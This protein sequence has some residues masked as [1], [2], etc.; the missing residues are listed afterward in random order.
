MD[1]PKRSVGFGLWPES[2][3][4]DSNRRPELYESAG[5][6]RNQRRFKDLR[7]RFRDPAVP[8]TLRAK[9]GTIRDVS[10]L[11][12]YLERPDS[13]TLAF[14]ILINGDAKRGREVAN[15][16]VRLLAGGS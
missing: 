15:A 1:H 9:T 12:G 13:N 2:H 10:A 4:S 6:F 16:I 7:R 8:G 3:P 5:R 11:A 14:A